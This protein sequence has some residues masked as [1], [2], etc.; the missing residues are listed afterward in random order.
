MRRSKRGWRRNQHES[1]SFPLRTIVDCSATFAAFQQFLIETHCSVERGWGNLIK[2]SFSGGLESGQFDPFFT[3]DRPGEV[4]V[5]Q[6]AT[7]DVQLLGPL[8][9]IFI[10]SG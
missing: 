2:M 7:P 4:T 3:R 6:F 10:R 5:D 1:Y 8:G 9:F